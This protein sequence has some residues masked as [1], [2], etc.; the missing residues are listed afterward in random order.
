[1]I[2]KLYIYAFVYTQYVIDKN[3]FEPFWFSRMTRLLNI[4]SLVLFNDIYD[5]ENKVIE[6]THLDSRKYEIVFTM[7]LHNKIK[8][9]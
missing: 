7:L 5:F 3:P 8:S 2:S 6:E 9:L 4:I 1:M